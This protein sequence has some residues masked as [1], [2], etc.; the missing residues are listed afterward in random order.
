[1]KYH[2]DRLWNPF[3]DGQVASEPYFSDA[4]ATGNNRNSAELNMN[5][6]AG[7]E[8]AYQSRGWPYVSYA[9]E[10]SLMRE[11]Y[12]ST[13]QSLHNRN[14]RLLQSLESYESSN[15]P[16]GRV[17]LIERLRESDRQFGYL[18][19][20]INDI[21]NELSVPQNEIESFRRKECEF[22]RYAEELGIV[23]NSL[24]RDCSVLSDTVEVG[25]DGRISKIFIRVPIPDPAR[26]FREDGGGDQASWYGNDQLEDFENHSWYR[27]RDQGVG[28]NLLVRNIMQGTSL[29]ET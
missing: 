6:P 26:H 17:N 3:A 23:N 4:R 10:I 18:W 15:T 2:Y 19:I 21:L 24:E 5:R 20:V 9:S 14:T 1:M 8:Y 27:N 16:I 22:L 7:T 28:L 29:G 12:R 25:N 13:I 11:R